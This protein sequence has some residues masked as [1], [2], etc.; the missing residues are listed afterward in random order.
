MTLTASR[1]SP[2]LLII[3]DGWGY[4]L[5]SKANAIA[6]A[7][8]PCWDALW[9]KYP[10]TLLSGS[11]RCVGLPAGQMGNSEVGH[12]TMGAGRVVYQDL[13]RI[14]RSIED[15]SFFKNSTLIAA[16]QKLQREGKALHLI[17]LL[18]PGGV[19][20][21]ERHFHELLTVAAALQIAPVYLHL[22]LD[23]RDTPPRSARASLSALIEK[24]KALHCGEIVS[25]IGR[26]YAMDRDHRWDRTQKAYELLV[27]GKGYHDG[28]D[29]LMALEQA[30][31]RGE[32]DEFV[33]ATFLNQTKKGTIAPCDAVIFM[34]FRADRARQLTQ[35]FV[36]PDFKGFPRH[37]WPALS[38]FITLTQY[39]DDHLATA[40][41]F[42]PVPLLHSLPEYL[43]AQ[44]LRQLRIAETE[45]YAHVTYFF[46]GGLEKPF[47]GEERI[48]IP[49]PSVAT[50]DLKPEMSA[51]EL[52]RRLCEEINQQK[53]DVIICN[54]ANPDMV[55]HS[56]NFSATV[57]AI[58]AVDKCL[59]VL[60]S[61]LQAVGGEALITSDH[62]NAEFMF[63]E[64]TQQAHTA[65]T[66]ALVP[67]LYFGRKAQA[68]KAQGTLA[69]IAPTLL[70][71][72][73]LTQ[74]EEMT[75]ETLFTLTG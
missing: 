10:H 19:H 35:A 37:Q 39:D 68:T 33:Q 70:Y 61:A 51:Y 56:G 6:Q 53:Y 71:L 40:V 57:K 65:H 14:D 73:G 58:E 9:Q 26:Y 2:L 7:H 31:Q 43:S 29:P 36:D 74:P 55:G 62:G 1:P 15:G 45:K 32:S 63:D 18:S 13:T 54:Y 59:A 27:E 50:Y 67:A 49:S 23:G 64:K 21:H 69:D 34:N 41:A 60:I 16:L 30:Y 12:M 48:L 66:H 17:G 5:E 38:S 46:N 52:T 24:T 20:S 8:K 11:G 3:L 25:L 42:P 75:G 44:G 22:F 47:I 72:L 4:R 28:D